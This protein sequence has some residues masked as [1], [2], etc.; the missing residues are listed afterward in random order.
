MIGDLKAKGAASL[1]Q[2]A[3]GLNERRI[4]TAR[5]RT[6]SAVQVQRVLKV[7]RGL[8]NYF[9]SSVRLIGMIF[10]SGTTSCSTV[11]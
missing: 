1:H 8:T 2:I 5:G 9:D 7:A 3:S 4:K 10:P 11:L 6:W